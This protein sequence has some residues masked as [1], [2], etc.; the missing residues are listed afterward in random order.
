MQNSFENLDETEWQPETIGHMASRLFD[1]VS[2]YSWKDSCTP[3]ESE[4]KPRDELFA[5]WQK[6][7]AHPVPKPDKPL[8]TREKDGKKSWMAYLIYAAIYFA[9]IITYGF[10]TLPLLFLMLP[11]GYDMFLTERAKACEKAYAKALSAYEKSEKVQ[12]GYMYISRLDYYILSACDYPLEP[13]NFSGEFGYGFPNKGSYE[14]LNSPGMAEETYNHFL[15]QD[16][17]YPKDHYYASENVINTDPEIDD[18]LRGKLLEL[19]DPWLACFRA[20]IDYYIAKHKFKWCKSKCDQLGWNKNPERIHRRVGESREEY[21]ARLKQLRLWNELMQ[22]AGEELRNTEF[23][24]ERVA[25][26]YYELYHEI[27]QFSG[28]IASAKLKE[29]MSH[30]LGRVSQSYISEYKAQHSMD[31]QESYIDIANDMIKKQV[32]REKDL[33]DSLHQLNGDPLERYLAEQASAA[34]S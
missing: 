31:L 10:T 5:Q 17:R 18:I 12:H 32:Q 20:Y 24:Y 27:E 23:I 25:A 8:H 2:L 9:V 1:D 30:A 21:L 22:L 6:Q 33:A 19:I 13:D 28:I 16:Y 7:R 29:K 4:T 34:A 14:A 11:I 15:K 26:D 3:P